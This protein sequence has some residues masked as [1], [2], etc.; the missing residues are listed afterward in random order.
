MK[1]A[2]II[3]CVLI[4]VITG[5]A[6]L[7]GSFLFGGNYFLYTRIDNTKYTNFFKD[8]SKYFSYKLPAYSDDGARE[9]ITFETLRELRGGAFLK[10]EL[11]RLTGV[12]TWEEVVPEQLPSELRKF[13]RP[14]SQ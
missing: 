8:G 10:V 11:S 4:A 1:K 6:F 7:A 12:V 2:I 13:F 9:D 14:S 3:T 5:A